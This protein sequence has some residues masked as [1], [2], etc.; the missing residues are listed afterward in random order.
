MERQYNKTWSIHW[1]FHAIPSLDGL[2]LHIISADLI[3]DK[4]KHKKQ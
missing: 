2:H 3:S 4:L 1:G